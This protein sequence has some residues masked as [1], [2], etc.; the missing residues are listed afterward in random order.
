MKWTALLLFVLLALPGFAADLPGDRLQFKGNG[1]SI[2]PLEGR[3]DASF[4]ALMMFLP[5]SGQFAPNVNVQIQPHAG[6]IQEFADISRSQFKSAG[7]VVSDEKSTPSS[8][9]WEYSGAQQGRKLRFYARAEAGPGKVYLVTATATESQWESI[10][11]QLK[12]CVDS[13]RREAVDPAAPVAPAPLF[14]EARIL[15]T[16]WDVGGGNFFKPKARIAVTVAGRDAD[17]VK[18]FSVT[19]GGEA[20]ELQSITCKDGDKVTFDCSYDRALAAKMEIRLVDKAGKVLV[21]VS[22]DPTAK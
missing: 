17:A 2:A 16:L 1:F 10:G 11:A 20:S 12:A 19:A 18:L 6:T 9:T 13:F 4:C 22:R 5:A 7:F 8:F 15:V 14:A 3:S 21:V